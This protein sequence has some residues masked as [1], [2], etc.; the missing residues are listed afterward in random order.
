MTSASG[1]VERTSGESVPSMKCSARETTYSAFLPERPADRRPSFGHATTISGVG[2]N[3]CGHVGVGVKRA[4]KRDLIVRAAAP[5]TCCEIIPLTRLWKGLMSS[6]KPSAE[7]I[8][9]GWDSIRDFRLESTESRCAVAW[10]RIVF[11]V[12]GACRLI[13]RTAVLFA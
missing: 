7:N 8:S 2:K 4:M 13:C 10:S 12:A 1:A 6:A 9:Q 11:V 3:G 5:E